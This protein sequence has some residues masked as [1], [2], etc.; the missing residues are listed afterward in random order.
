MKEFNIFIRKIYT[1]LIDD[2][3]KS[4]RSRCKKMYQTM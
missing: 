1:Y 3:E 4:K 2:N